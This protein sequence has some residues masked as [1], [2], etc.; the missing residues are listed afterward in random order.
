[1]AA[2]MDTVDPL[3]NTSQ[4]NGV[5]SL[6]QG[7]GGIMDIW[8]TVSGSNRSDTNQ[9]INIAYPNAP[10]AG[11]YASMLHTAMTNPGAYKMTPGA[12]FAMEQG[13]QG[14]AR[15]GNSMFGTSRSGG[16]AI[17]LDKYA[18]G[19]AGQ[20]YNNYI[21]Q[22]TQL[23]QGNTAAANLFNQGNT[24]GDQ[25]IAGGLSAIDKLIQ[26]A[27]GQSGMQWLQQLLNGSGSAG[28]TPTGFSPDSQ[29]TTDSIN[30]QL[31]NDPYG[32]GT[33]GSNVDPNSV[34]AGQDIT[35]AFGGNSGGG[36]DPTGDFGWP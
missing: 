20:N 29:Q 21:Q 11:D 6:G 23:S 27:T 26:Q 7:I 9:A 10:Y 12:Q 25:N 4:G 36:F 1:M 33:Y 35:D 18:T 13:L 28:A 31:G 19:F 24:K 2:M 32:Q 14:V 22:L 8:N 30:Q 34:Q 3:L 5:G 16:T 15:Q 17:E